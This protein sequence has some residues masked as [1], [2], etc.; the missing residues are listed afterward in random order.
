V[1]H[2]S[3]TKPLPAYRDVFG[4]FLGIKILKFFLNVFTR[5]NHKKRNKWKSRGIRQWKRCKI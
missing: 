1:Q 2:A 4:E 3:S 5:Q